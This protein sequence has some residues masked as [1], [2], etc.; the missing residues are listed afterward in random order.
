MD[1]RL[2]IQ[3]SRFGLKTPQY[4]FGVQ[5]V[6][7]L[8]STP[9]KYKGAVAFRHNR[10]KIK[11]FLDKLKIILYNKVYFLIVFLYTI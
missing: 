2:D 10:K 6:L 7:W 3:S 5:G 8:Q 4:A 9:I 11:K 1:M